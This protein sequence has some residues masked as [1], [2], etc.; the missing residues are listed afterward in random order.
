MLNRSLRLA[1]TALALF[2]AL[3]GFLFLHSFESYMPVGPD[4]YVDVVRPAQDKAPFSEV[5]A[6]VEV[7][8][9]VEVYARDRR[10]PPARTLGRVRPFAQAGADLADSED[11]I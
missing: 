3:L 4:W 2:A 5:N 8:A 11:V 9:R 10:R 6:R 1:H 7:D